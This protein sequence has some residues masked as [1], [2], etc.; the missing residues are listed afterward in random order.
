[1]EQELFDL[2]LHSKKALLTGQGI[3][4]E[5][6]NFCE[7]SE[8]CTE[9]M[10]KIHPKLL[11]VNNYILAQLV[12]LERMREYNDLKVEEFKTKIKANQTNKLTNIFNLL[13]QRTIDKDI[14]KVNKERGQG[15]GRVEKKVTLF[16][17]ISDEAIIELQRQADDEIGEMEMINNVLENQ[18]RNIALAV[19]ELASMREATLIT[20]LEEPLSFAHEKLRI[21]GRETEKMAEILTDFTK[22]YDQI[23][24]A[25][26][27]YQSSPEACDDLDITILEE[28]NEHIPDILVQQEQMKVLDELEYFGTSGQADVIC[29]KIMDAEVAMKNKE[30]SLD[31]FFQQLSSLAERYRFYAS[32]YSYLLLEIERRKKAQIKLMNLRKEMIK[33]FEEAYDDE[34]QERKSWSAQHGEYLPEV[35]CPFINDLPTKLTVTVESESGRLPNLS[36]ESIEKALNEIHNAS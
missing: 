22:H 29:E 12:T 36:P 28:D 14:L 32:S 11:F 4:E 18:S 3:C 21:Q 10:E 8:R 33:V 24:E 17:H 15:D 7:A 9:T 19:S 5:A 35:L 23:V 31:D 26:K 30:C 13:K 16:D 1:M 27:I 25:T 20:P 2:F 34:L 6:N